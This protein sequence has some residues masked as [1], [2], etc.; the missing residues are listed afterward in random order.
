MATQPMAE[1]EDELSGGGA[2]SDE[3]LANHLSEHERRAIGYYD[4]EIAS[5]QASAIDRYYRRPYGDERAG[6]S[7]VVDGTVAITVDNAL[8][9]ILKPF[10]SADETVTF[11]PRSK[12]DE[13][14]AAQAT[15]YV[16]YVLHNDN[17]GFLI[18]HDWFKDAL[19]CKLGVVKADPEAYSND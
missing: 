1:P 9:A 18:L 14:V 4:T 11:Q 8:A 2:M 10:V 12:E 7:A 15:E 17:G 5:E 3:E 13:D 16:N 19:L 6:K